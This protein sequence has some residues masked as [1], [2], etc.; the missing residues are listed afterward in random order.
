[1]KD[2]KDE[3]KNERWAK[4]LEL[5][6]GD[7][8]YRVV[9]E[10]NGSFP[11]RKFGKLVGEQFQETEQ[12]CTVSDLV[13]QWLG[14][15]PRVG[16]IVKFAAWKLRVEE[17]AGTRVAKIKLTCLVEATKAASVQRTKSTAPRR[18]EPHAVGQHHLQMEDAA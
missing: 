13:T 8:Q 18:M 4:D 3:G 14:R 10:V 2:R 1:M 16:D 11:I 17:M 5:L 15:F 9:V 6:P 7:D 12:V